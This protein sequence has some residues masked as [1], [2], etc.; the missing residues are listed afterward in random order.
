M[1]IKD[2]GTVVLSKDEAIVFGATMFGVIQGVD[3]KREKDLYISKKEKEL[4][5]MAKD[6][7][8]EMEEKGLM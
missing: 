8:E 2:N 1:E 7:V 3:E 6:I 5:K 4:Y